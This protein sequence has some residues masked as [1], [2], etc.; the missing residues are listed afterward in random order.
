ML[1]RLSGFPLISGVAGFLIGLVLTLCLNTILFAALFKYLPKTAIRWREVGIGAFVTAVLWEIA[2]RLLA[3]YIAHSNYT[4]LYGTVGALLA[5]MAWVYFSSQI[6][7]LGAEFTE[8]YSRRYCGRAAQPSASSPAEPAKSQP[9]AEA[10][11]AV[12]RSRT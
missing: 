5:I 10:K 7:F 9:K 3:L 11:A 12:D 4:S 2:K 6:L 1:T 8:V